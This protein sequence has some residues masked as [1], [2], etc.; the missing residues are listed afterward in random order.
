M[1]QA[2]LTIQT[3]NNYLPKTCTTGF[4]LPEKDPDTC[5]AFPNVAKWH[6][7]LAPSTYLLICSDIYCVSYMK[8]TRQMFLPVKDYSKI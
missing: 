8:F 7:S 6:L 1:K 4:K 3:I 2:G 5:L